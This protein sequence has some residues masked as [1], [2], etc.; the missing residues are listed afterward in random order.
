MLFIVSDVEVSEAPATRPELAVEVR[1]RRRRQVR[2]LLALRADDV[3][4]DPAFEGLCSRCVDAVSGTHRGSAR[5]RMDR[6][7]RCCAAPSSGWRSAS[8]PPIRRP[9]R[10]SAPRIG[11]HD[12]V[13][14][15]PGLLN[16]THVLNTGAAF[17]LLNAA[18]FPF[19][20]LVVALLAIGAL[21]AIAFYAMTFGSETRLARLSLTLILAGAC[22]NLIDRAV[23]RRGR[24]LRRRLLAAR[25]TSGRST[26]R[27]RPSRSARF[28]SC[29]TCSGPESMYP[30][31]LELGPLTLYSYGL[32]LAL[33]YLAGLQLALVRARARGLDGGRVMDL[34]IWIIISALVGAKLL[35]LDRRLRHASRRTRASCSRWRS[36]AA[37]ST[38]G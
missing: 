7:I 24:R 5:S 2:A 38:A 21:V 33:A 14:V 34:G 13:E 20:S 11:L 30:R 23:V 8:S 17:G 36:R 9:R 4:T 31:L 29:S 35:L 26:S 28:C 25:G 19:K 32:L 12:N 37:S 3:S 22:G 6:A 16:L 27:T 1:A 10:W 15:V 18:D